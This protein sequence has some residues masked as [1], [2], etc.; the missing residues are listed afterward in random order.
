MNDEDKRKDEIRADIKEVRQAIHTLHRMGL[1]FISGSLHRGL[2][3]G[4]PPDRDLREEQHDEEAV[5]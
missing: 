3:R 4:L 2:P 1:R 5:S